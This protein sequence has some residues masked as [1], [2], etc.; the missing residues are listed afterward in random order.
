M[1][2]IIVATQYADWLLVGDVKLLVEPG[3]RP[4]KSKPR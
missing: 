1:G 4:L 3:A 2:R